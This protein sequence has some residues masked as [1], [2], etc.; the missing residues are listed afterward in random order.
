MGR[1]LFANEAEPKDTDLLFRRQILRNRVGKVRHHCV[2][3]GVVTDRLR[4]DV[5]LTVKSTSEHL[6]FD[7]K[8]YEKKSLLFV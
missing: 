4:V 1:V 2:R 5:F 6:H 8:K 3:V 7:T